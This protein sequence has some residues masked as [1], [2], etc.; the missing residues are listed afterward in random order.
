MNITITE[1]KTHLSKYLNKVLKE[2]I[3]LSEEGKEVAV[4][5]SHEEYEQFI[6]L[7]DEVWA[8]RALEARESGYVDNAIEKLNQL[9]R[10]KT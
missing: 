10:D 4:V 7:E 6:R 2:P 8:L 5:I 1:F 3:I 9:A